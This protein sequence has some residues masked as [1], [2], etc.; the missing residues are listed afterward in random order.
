M[1][2]DSHLV[3]EVAVN[4]YLRDFSSPEPKAPG[5]LGIGRLRRPSSSVNKFKQ[6]LLWNY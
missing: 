5:S 3:N 2:E 1:G 6:L 4:D